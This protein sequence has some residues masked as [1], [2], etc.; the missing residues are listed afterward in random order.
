M[1][2][3][4]TQWKI[5]LSVDADSKEQAIAYFERL[6]ENMRRDGYKDSFRGGC[7]SLVDEG[8]CGYSMSVSKPYSVPLRPYEIAELREL[9]AERDHSRKQGLKAQPYREE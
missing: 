2:D 7:S 3:D 8:R 1:A 6:A 5:S 4:L 9:L